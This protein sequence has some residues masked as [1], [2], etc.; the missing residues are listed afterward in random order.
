MTPERI[1]EM[2]LSA[3]DRAGIA[4]LMTR[5]FGTDFGGRDYYKQRHHLRLIIRDQGGIVGHMAICLRSIR[6]GDKRIDIVGLAEVATDPDHQGKGIASC[7]MQE[8]LVEADQSPADFFLLFGDRPL[9]AAHGFEPQPNPLRFLDI[10]EGRST[11]VTTA[12]DHALMVRPLRG[13]SWDA[14]APVDLLGPEF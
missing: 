9:Y 13:T 4:R 3:E 11:Q 6:S 8:A 12:S 2:R 7:L 5:A 14:E 1:E 10:A